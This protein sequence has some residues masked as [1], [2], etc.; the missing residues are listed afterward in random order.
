MSRRSM[1]EPERDPQITS[2]SESGSFG[3][4]ARVRLWT[5]DDERLNSRAGV[6]YVVTGSMGKPRWLV[7]TW[8]GYGLWVITTFN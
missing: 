1:N 3:L 6:R 7:A 8:S 4:L 2:S 5:G